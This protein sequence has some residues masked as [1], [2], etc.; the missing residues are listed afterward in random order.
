MSR[1]QLQPTC[2]ATA[3]CAKV[4]RLSSAAS[5]V[6]IL[7]P[8]SS[9]AWATLGL[10]HVSSTGSATAPNCLIMLSRSSLGISAFE[11]RSVIRCP[12]CVW[13][14]DTAATRNVTALGSSSQHLDHVAVEH[15]VIASDALSIESGRRT[16]DA[17]AR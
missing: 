3:M 14:E 15:D 12:P 11:I 10:C 4:L 5:H 2:A 7:A 17:G 9:A 1:H 6:A 13:H 8:S 16:P